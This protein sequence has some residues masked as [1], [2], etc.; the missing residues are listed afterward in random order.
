MKISKGL[1]GAILGLSLL[2]AP[3]CASAPAVAAP[4]APTSV[5]D[6]VKDDN[7]AEIQEVFNAVNAFRASKGLAPVNYNVYAANVAQDWSDYMGAE[8]DFSHNPDFATDPR[9]SGTQWSGEIIAARWDRSGA[10]LVKQWINSDAH[11]ATMSDP[12]F[13]TIGIGITYTNETG[14]TFETTGRAA[15]YGIIDFYRFVPNKEK[16]FANPLDAKNNTNPLPTAPTPTPTPTPVPTPIPTPTPTP[17]PTP[18]PVDPTPTPGVKLVTPATPTFD[19]W[20]QGYTIPAQSG[21]IYAVNGTDVRGG[22]YNT[23][24]TAVK[25]TAKAMAGYVLNGTSEWSY[26]YTP[27]YQIPKVPGSV[28]P[29][30]FS[31]LKNVPPLKKTNTYSES[32]P[33]KVEVVAPAQKKSIVEYLTGKTTEP[34]ATAGPLKSTTDSFAPTTSQENAPEAARA[35]EVNDAQFRAG[36]ADG[37]K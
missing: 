32:A 7:F 26:K 8:A 2:A 21:V 31:D 4:I 9:I 14:K 27:T 18:V 10:A 28:G 11:N 23:R 16:T 5:S 22:T 37:M 20:E 35:P 3:I 13:T 12:N 24:E 15:T 30:K 6:L 17:T 36:M 34:Q 19:N 33:V 25:I 29:V 1:T